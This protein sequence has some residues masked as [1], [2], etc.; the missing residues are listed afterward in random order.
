MSATRSRGTTLRSV[1]RTI[2]GAVPKAEAMT[3]RLPGTRQRRRRRIADE[4]PGRRG[5][6]SRGQMTASTRRARPGHLPR[7]PGQLLRL[8]ALCWCTGCMPGR[9]RCLRCYRRPPAPLDLAVLPARPS[10][11][12]A[13]CSVVAAGLVSPHFRRLHIG[14]GRRLHGDEHRIRC[15]LTHCEVTLTYPG[16]LRSTAPRERVASAA[17]LRHLRMHA[18]R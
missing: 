13:T 11:P 4:V 17:P 18:W 2:G 9:A 14:D 3:R 12:A 16:R 6:R 1:T 5:L 15:L 10:S 8:R 7:R